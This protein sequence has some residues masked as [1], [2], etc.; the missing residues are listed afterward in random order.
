MGVGGTG[1]PIARVATTLIGSASTSTLPV[2]MLSY[3]ENQFDPSIAAISA[4]QLLIALV[5]LLLLDRVYG[6]ER[7]NP[8][9]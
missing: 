9:E 1:G 7:A 5:A 6:I 3:M 4:V 2:I 8:V